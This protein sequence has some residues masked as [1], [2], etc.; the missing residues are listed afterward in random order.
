MYILRVLGVL[1]STPYVT[2]S[3]ASANFCRTQIVEALLCTN[4][5]IL[6]YVWQLC[7]KLALPV[8][9]LQN[10]TEW[11]HLWFVFDSRCRTTSFCRQKKKY[12]NNQSVQQTDRRAISRAPGGL[13]QRTERH[14][15]L[16]STSSFQAPS[17][18]RT[19]R[20]EYSTG[21]I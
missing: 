20:Q 17:T 6:G 15:K 2:P 5:L 16:C 4:R 14:G 12:N 7:I 13:L 10:G 11:D 21:G 19:M 18:A 3:S 9:S 8:G 1:R